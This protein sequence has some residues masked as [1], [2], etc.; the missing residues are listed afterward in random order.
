MTLHFRFRP[1]I[2]YSPLQLALSRRGGLLL[3]FLATNSAALNFKTGRGSPTFM[4]SLPSWAPGGSRRQPCGQGLPPMWPDGA[5]VKASK[6][7]DLDDEEDDDDDDV[8]EDDESSTDRWVLGLGTPGSFCLAC[9][10]SSGICCLWFPLKGDH[11]RP[12]CFPWPLPDPG[13]SQFR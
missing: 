6:A 5:V 10:C 11:G 4:G 13:I 2:L 9:R 7:G 12:L 1:S 3:C 8:K